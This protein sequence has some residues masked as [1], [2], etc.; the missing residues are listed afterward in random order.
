MLKEIYSRQ[1]R[2]S[3]T[4]EIDPRNIHLGGSLIFSP[5]PQLLDVSKYNKVY[6]EN[7]IN[8]HELNDTKIEVL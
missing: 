2:G 6:T 8:L 5:S 4:I 1:K 7:D 3:I